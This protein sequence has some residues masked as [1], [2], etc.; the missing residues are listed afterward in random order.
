MQTMSSFSMIIFQII[1]SLN[2]VFLLCIYL[3]SWL[4][5]SLFFILLL[6]AYF[7]FIYTLHWLYSSFSSFFQNYFSFIIIISLL[8]PATCLFFYLDIFSL[9]LLSLSASSSSF[10]EMYSSFHFSVPSFI[11]LLRPLHPH[12]PHT[13]THTLPLFLI[14]IHSLAHPL[15]LLLLLMQTVIFI[16]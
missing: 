8:Y 15:L 9:V 3:L 10:D 11:P 7:L 1:S 14:D 16:D 13:H 12:S 4:T 5:A 6:H 2:I